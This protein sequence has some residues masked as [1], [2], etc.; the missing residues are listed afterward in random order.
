MKKIVLL[1][2]LCCLVTIHSFSQTLNNIEKVVELQNS[3]ANLFLNAQNWATA[4]ASGIVTKIDDSGKDNGTLAAVIDMLMPKLENSKTKY[5][6]YELKCNSKI[7]CSDGKYQR[8]FLY[9]SVI[10]GIEKKADYTHVPTNQLLQMKAELKMIQDLS[11][12]NFKEIFEWKL[13]DVVK[14]YNENKTQLDSLKTKSS[15]A[16]INKKDKKQLSVQIDKLT[17]INDILE[18]V[19]N[20]VNNSFN[21]LAK[22]IDSAM[23]VKK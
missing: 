10:L 22:E 5:I 12:S 7:D 2:M 14:F 17:S 9:P 20:R 16:S 15:D 1:L 23:L 3:K 13:D 18:E 19:I 8:T 11:M 6:L 21:T 4:N